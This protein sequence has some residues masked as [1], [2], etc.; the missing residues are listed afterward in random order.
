M[1]NI[2]EFWKQLANKKEITRADIAA[3]CLLKALRQE[4]PALAKI[5]LNQSFKPITNTV[6]IANGA[7]PRYALWSALGSADSCQTSKQLTDEEK[8]ALKVLASSLN[9]SFGEVNL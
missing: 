4:D 2:R 7:Y 8:K 3:L 6:K 1:T 9:G 5:Y